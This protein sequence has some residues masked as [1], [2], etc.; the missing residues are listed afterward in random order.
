MRPYDPQEIPIFSE[1]RSLAPSATGIGRST[2]EDFGH[3][4]ATALLLP[5]A[6]AIALSGRALYLFLSVSPFLLTERWRLGPSEAGHC[7][8]FVAGAGVGGTIVA[9]GAALGVGAVR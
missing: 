2:L 4:L 1:R 5:L 9:R 6:S 3:L 7:Y 8:P